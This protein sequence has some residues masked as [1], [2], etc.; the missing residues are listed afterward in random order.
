MNNKEQKPN[1]AID[2]QY[3]SRRDVTTHSILHIYPKL[4]AIGQPYE[5]QT[6]IIFK[7]P[8]PGRH[9]LTPDDIAFLNKQ[10]LRILEKRK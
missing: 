8:F 2:T 5:D 9:L 6:D 10:A 4:T 3:D 1:I 7:W